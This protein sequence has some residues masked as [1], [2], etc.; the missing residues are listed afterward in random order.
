[1]VSGLLLLLILAWAGSGSGLAHAGPAG[2]S[3]PTALDGPGLV[4]G[5]TMVRGPA[6]GQD[7]PGTTTTGVPTTTT[8][9][10]P[11]TTTTIQKPQDWSLTMVAWWGME[12][13][14]GTTRTADPNSSCGFAGNNCDLLDSLAGVERSATHV[15]GSYSAYTKETDN[16]QLSCAAATCE[17]LDPD[18]SLVVGGWVFTAPTDTATTYLANDTNFTTKG[19]YI[20]RTDATNLV[21]CWFGNGTTFATKNSATGAMPE[22]AWTHV[23]CEMDAISNEIIPYINGAPS[24]CVRGSTCAVAI[25]ATFNDASDFKVGRTTLGVNGLFDEFFVTEEPLTSPAVCRICS[26]GINGQTGPCECSG[27]SYTNDG[28]R[29]TMCGSCDMSAIACNASP[30]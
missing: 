28:R 26:C 30:P 10:T 6:S 13:A 27:T 18:G 19:F 15:E 21:T 14:S 9:A 5:P 22:G 7:L 24:G 25:D 17:E 3:G 1:M 11:T 29:T 2:L 23:L 8:T 12:Q 4:S 16:E 20:T